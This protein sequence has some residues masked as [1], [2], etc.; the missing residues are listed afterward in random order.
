MA[1][2]NNVAIVSAAVV[3][4]MGSSLHLAIVL[5]N[6]RL[7]LKDTNNFVRFFFHT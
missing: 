2:V 1:P 3:V 4:M 6:V 5:I 7:V